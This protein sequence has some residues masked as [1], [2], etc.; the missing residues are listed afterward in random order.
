M[1]AHAPAVA[2]ADLPHPLRSPPER[3]GFGGIGRFGQPRADRVSGQ[4]VEHRL[5][6]ALC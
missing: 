4:L 2:A 3:G 6:A 5:A 1:G